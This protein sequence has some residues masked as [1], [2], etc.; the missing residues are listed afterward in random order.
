MRRLIDEAA[1][2]EH[3]Y[4]VDKALEKSIID[5]SLYISI[6]TYASI[7]PDDLRESIFKPLREAFRIRSKLYN[8]N[9]ITEL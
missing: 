9:K 7:R 6:V 1:T 8:V 5:S 4:I 3:F 2:T